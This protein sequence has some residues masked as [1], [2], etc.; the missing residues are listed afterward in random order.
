MKKSPISQGC[1]RSRLK[2]ALFGLVFLV[3]AAGGVL[4]SKSEQIILGAEAYIFGYPLVVTDVTRASATLLAGPE[5]TLRRVKQFP[6]A[7][8]RDVV[9]P[10]VDT[11][12]T[13]A[14]INMDNGPWVFEFAANDR[15]YEV[16]PFMDAWTNVFAAPGT[17]TT[18]TGGGR[19]LLVD[20]RW[21]GVVPSGLTLLRSPTQMVWLIGRTQTNGV[22]DYPLVHQLQDGITLRTLADWQAGKAAVVPVWQAGVGKPVPPVAQMRAMRSDV[23]FTRLAWLMVGNPPAAADGPMLVKL[24]RLG[25]APGRPPS[26]GVLDL[27]AVSLGRW[28]ADFTVARELK[29]P[30]DLIRGWATPP[31]ILGN[32]GTY[33]NTRAVV[34]M[35]GLGANL[36]ADATYPNTGVDA[37]GQALSGSR[38]YRVHFKATELPPVKAFWSITAYGP[39]D[40]L[41]DNPLHRY[42]LSDRDPLVFNPDGSL[43]LWLQADAPPPA[44]MANW[45]PVKADETFLL[46]ARLY[47]PKP[48]ALNGVWGMPAVERVE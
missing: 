8:F 34:A 19:F 7:E 32:Y 44:K 23:F 36:P 26:W 6:A 21:T 15:R 14:F 16:M 33:Y 27:A 11:L 40:F 35:V 17:R 3:L 12:Y 4:Y 13:T 24:S 9:R 25:I 22:A 46:N 2:L 30:R 41:I 18:G 10:N 47:W 43:D 1:R 5:N 39:D 20:R 37:T 28:L 38:R 31:A 45:L 42:A 48:A 29:K